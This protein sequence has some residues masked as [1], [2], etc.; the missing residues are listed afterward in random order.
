MAQDITSQYV[1]LGELAERIGLD[2]SNARKWVLKSGFSFFK[3]RDPRTGNQLVAAVTADEAETLMEL[4]QD[5]GYGATG[6]II[7]GEVGYFYV[8][9]LVPD[10]DQRRIKLGFANDANSRLQ[11]HRTSA[12]T[13]MLL[14][15]W[16]C[17]RAWEEAAIA[18]VTRIE[19]RLIAS[20]VYE[21]ENTD[22]LL[23]RGD[24]FFALMPKP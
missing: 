8:V 1:T 7:N 16:P 13:A 22:S 6:K 21:C 2:R 23:A 15:A 10:L 14:K 4:R 17:R 9:Q 20:E 19:S 24:A 18:S 11:A 5:Q 3:V 12:P